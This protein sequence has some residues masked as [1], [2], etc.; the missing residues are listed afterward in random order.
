MTKKKVDTPEFGQGAKKTHKGSSKNV[1]K[2]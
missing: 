2:R 1:K